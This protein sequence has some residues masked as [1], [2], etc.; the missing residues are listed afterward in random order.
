MA[1]AARAAQAWRTYRSVSKPGTPG[2][3][4]RLRALPK[5]IGAVMR[6]RYPGMSK[7][8]LAMMG[9]GVLYIISP[10]DVIPDFLVLIGV[11]DDFGLFL[12]LMSSLLGEGGRYVD[13]EREQV[14]AVPS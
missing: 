5:M 1:K 3:G 8:K 6:G 11:A 12:W 13:W 2:L 14:R 10:I 9:L 7:G 4:A